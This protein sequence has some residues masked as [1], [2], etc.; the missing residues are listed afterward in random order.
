MG[1]GGGLA[2]A[3]TVLGYTRGNELF[4]HT[5]PGF[6]YDR[7]PFATLAGVCAGS[8]IASVDGY[9]SLVADTRRRANHNKVEVREL[10]G[11]QGSAPRWI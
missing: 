1:L 2:S 9:R 7:T 8:S 11:G 5:G 6:R 10:V 4:V 3:F